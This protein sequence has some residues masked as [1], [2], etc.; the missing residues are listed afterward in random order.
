MRLAKLE[1]QNFR[2]HGNCGWE[3]GRDSVVF[4]GPNTVG[5][6]NVLE[7][8]YLLG[9]G[10]TFREAKVEEMVNWEGEVGRVVGVV[11]KGKE[12]LRRS[13]ASHST[14][15]VQDD[16]TGMKSIPVESS[17][18]EVVELE[19]VVTRGVVQGRR[20][21]KRRY[22]VNGVG[23][24]KRTFLG[25]LIVVEFRPEDMRIVE[26]SP[27]RRRKFLDRILA[28]VDGEYGRALGA[29]NK[30]LARRNKLLDMIRE[31]RTKRSALAFWDELVIRNGVLIQKHRLGLAEFMNKLGE[32]SEFGLR[33]RYKASP[34]SRKRLD[35]Y[36]DREI[37]AGYT[38]VG[39]HRDD[40][41]VEKEFGG[42]LRNLA[43]YGSRGE[44]RLGVLWL[45]MQAMEFVD[46]KI[47]ER[48]VLLLDDILSELDEE[49][50]ELVAGL[51]GKQQTIATTA[52]EDF[53]RGFDGSVQ[54]IDL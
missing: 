35:E 36:A 45:K 44:Q 22:L 3:F 14:R 30:A 28:Q 43:A 15:H 24:A 41:W 51:F 23:R 50:R 27:G 17:E 52:N 32:Y 11:G 34:M 10:E 47:G 20:V 46:D 37:Y 33:M 26:G 48:P 18:G 21:A 12:I 42:E 4:V 39:P 31:G 6:T 19:V 54:R 29:Y 8:I 13:G 5:K 2:N 40:F 53:I 16:S 9:A 25:N 1:L 38:L 7:A 49:H